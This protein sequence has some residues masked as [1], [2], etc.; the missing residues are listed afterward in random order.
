MS[1]VFD[2]V[3]VPEKDGEPSQP[4]AIT[5]LGRDSASRVPRL[6]RDAWSMFKSLAAVQSP[7]NSLAMLSSVLE[8]RQESRSKLPLGLTEGLRDDG[9]F[10]G[11]SANATVRP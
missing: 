1:W 7:R 3:S 6:R 11:A 9:P 5:R 2:H 8:E 4:M 10:P